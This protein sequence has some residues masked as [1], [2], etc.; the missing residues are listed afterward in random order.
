MFLSILR[1]NQSLPLSVRLKL[2]SSYNKKPRYSS[3][4]HN[5]N[6]CLITGRTHGNYR[7]FKMSRIKLKEYVSKGL[8]PGVRKS[9]W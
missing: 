9:S 1:N 7:L 8:I 4:S 6:R 2:Q 5:N 3:F